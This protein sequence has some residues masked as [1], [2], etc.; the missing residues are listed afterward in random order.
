MKF[1]ETQLPGGFVLEIERR[2]DDRGYFAR[3]WCQTELAAYGLDPTAV[4]ANVGFSQRR[5]TLRGMH[6]QRAPHAEVKI[7]RCTRGAVFDVMIDLR[8][9]S[10]AEGQWVGV[11]LTAENGKLLYIPEG[12]AHGYQT[13]TD[14]AEI[15][16]MTSKAYA[17]DAAAG[18][19]Y[20]DP[21]FNIAWPLEVASISD[22]DR[23]WPDYGTSLKDESIKEMQL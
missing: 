12:F 16:Y 21:A 5:G 1:K 3:A 2:G 10:P 20:N 23:S 13:L 8:P 9:N 4:Q 14:E 18:V 17:P 11:E 6:F 7:V 15:H 22:A 19:R